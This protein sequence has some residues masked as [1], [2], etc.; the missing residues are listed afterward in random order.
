MLTDN[1]IMQQVMAA[2]QEEQA[3]HRQ[4]IGDILLEL[5][6]KPDHPKQNELVVQLFR[7]AHSLKGGARAA[8]LEAVEQLAHRVEDIF[9]AVRDGDLMLSANI[10]DIVYAAL[11]AIGALMNKV[12]NGQPASLAAYQPLLDSLSDALNLDTQQTEDSVRA[13]I[14]ETQQTQT[15]KPESASPQASEPSPGEPQASESAE[16]DQAVHP[17]ESAQ[18]SLRP[19]HNH[20]QRTQNLLLPLAR[21]RAARKRCNGKPPI[22]LSAS[23]QRCSIV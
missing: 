16:P 18:H 4:A 11:E 6:Q 12:T 20:W 23:R 2:F 17:A 9:S 21:N 5:E 22:Q 3:E 19:M 15:T 1:E 10:C 13:N 7:E 8:G 14:A